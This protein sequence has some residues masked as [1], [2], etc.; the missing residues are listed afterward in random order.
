MTRLTDTDA[1][2]RL[3]LAVSQHVQAVPGVVRMTDGAGIR[4]V[5]HYAAGTVTGVVLARNRIEVHVA[6]D[7]LPLQ[8][9]ADAV[10]AATRAAVERIS[11]GTVEMPVVVVCVDDIELAEPTPRFA[12]DTSESVALRWRVQVAQGSA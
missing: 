10:Q 4:A 6:V 9:V 1:R 5:T 3:A 11:D 7:Q 2:A 8:P 12:L